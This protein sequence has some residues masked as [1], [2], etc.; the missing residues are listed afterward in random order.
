[1]RSPDET[2]RLLAVATSLKAR[3]L[4]SLSYGCGL[5]AGE[6]VRLKVK[7]IESA[8]RIIRI[9]SSRAA[10]IAMSCCRRRPASRRRALRRLP[11]PAFREAFGFYVGLFRAAGSRRAGAKRRSPT[12]TR[13]SRRGYIAMYV[14]RPLEHRRVHACA[15]RRSRC[16]GAA[17]HAGARRR[18]AR[19]VARR[20]RE[21]GG[22]AR[23]AR[24]GRGVGA[25]R[26]SSPAGAAARVLPSHRR[27]PGAARGVGDG[28]LDSSPY[29]RRLLGAARA[30]AR[31]AQDPRV[32][33][34]RQ[35]VAEHAETAVRDGADVDAALAALDRDV[36]GI[37]EKR[38]WMLDAARRGASAAEAR[39][40][41]PA[42]Q[43]RRD[44]RARD[45]RRR[46]GARAV[47]DGDATRRRGCSSRPRW[48]LIVVFFFLPVVA[49]LLLS[50]T[51]FD[52]YAVADPA[53]AALRRARA[54]TRAC[55]TI[56]VFWLALRNTFYF[57]ARRR[58][59]HRSPSRSA[60]RCS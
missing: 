27:P 13:T 5:R 25:G 46:R 9:S 16:V 51:D 18:R 36:D 33:A 44:G 19:R 38:R 39:R 17:P 54:T 48:L 23:V 45:P 58:A 43:T 21:P 37:L 34:H 2:R 53:N 60:R 15:C 3:V 7:H 12:S 10:R 30:R 57:V 56:R 28:A 22:L 8:Q 55:C 20:R 24:G 31:D 32:G 59:A 14:T 42:A 50:V 1:M 52:I 49:S 35:Q 47:A 6:V 26:V 11:R 40:A 4:L 29:A 41:E